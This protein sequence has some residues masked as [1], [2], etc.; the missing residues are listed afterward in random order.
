MVL[1]LGFDSCKK[2]D[3]P[4]TTPTTVAGSYKINTL[5]VTPSV[6]NAFSDLVAASK[7]LFNNTTCLTDLTITFKTDG[8]ATTDSPASCKS[9][10]DGSGN[11]IPISTFTGIDASSKWVQ[12]GTTLTVTKGDGT[13]TDYTVVSTSPTLKLQWMGLLNYPVPST[14]VYTFTMDL[15]KQ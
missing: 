1:L 13:K 9:V 11:Q 2:S 12:S 5:T 10:V 8:T 4:T 15:Q 14:T 7:L 3:D 6:Q